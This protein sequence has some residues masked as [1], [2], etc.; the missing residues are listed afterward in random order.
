MTKLIILGDS[1]DSLWP[2][3]EVHLR[4]RGCDRILHLGDFCC[5]DILRRFEGIAPVTAVRGNN[6][7]TMED[8][9]PQRFFHLEGLGFY[10]IHDRRRAGRVRWDYDIF[11]SGHTHLFEQVV[12][13]RGI[14]YLNPGSC[15][16]RRGDGTVSYVEMTVD[17]GSYNLVHRTFRP[18]FR[19]GAP[20]AGK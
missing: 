8:L 4:E 15:G 14:L 16:R 7:R 13:D 2:D 17:K 3:F 10:M 11:L 6:D 1:H 20:V 12:T 18:A 19:M 9:P 5:R